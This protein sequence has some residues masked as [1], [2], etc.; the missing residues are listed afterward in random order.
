VSRRAL[1][2]SLIAAATLAL[3]ACESNVER[4]AKLECVRLKHNAALRASDHGRR[5]EPA[6]AGARLPSGCPAT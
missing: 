3:A 2:I 5:P 1:S 4:S 6:G